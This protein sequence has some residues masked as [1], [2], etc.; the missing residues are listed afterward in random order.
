ML[1]YL[2]HPYLYTYSPMHRTT[3]KEEL[4]YD[5]MVDSH[6]RS[7][8]LSPK[9]L[10]VITLGQTLLVCVDFSSALR[11]APIQSRG[12]WKGDLHSH[13]GSAYAVNHS[14]SKYDSEADTWTGLVD[15]WSDLGE[16]FGSSLISG[17]IYIIGT[18]PDRQTQ[19]VIRKFSLLS[20]EDTSL[21]YFDNTSTLPLVVYA[22]GRAE[23]ALISDSHQILYQ[24]D[25]STFSQA[26]FQLDRS[27]AVLQHHSETSVFVLKETGYILQIASGQ[28]WETKVQD[29][30]EESAD[31]ESV[32][33]LLEHDKRVR[34][35]PGL[36]TYAVNF[37]E[38]DYFCVRLDT[39][40]LT[41]KVIPAKGEPLIAKGAGIGL[42]PSG[43][44]MLAGGFDAQLQPTA[45]VMVWNPGADLRSATT[46][47]PHA[48]AFVVLA[49]DAESVYALGNVAEIEQKQRCEPAFQSYFQRYD[50]E[51]GLWTILAAPSVPLM[52]PGI[53]VL[54]G[55]IYSFCGSGTSQILTFDPA[56][57]QWH[58]IAISYPETLSLVLTF[59]LG[60]SLLCFSGID[61]S[62]NS[63]SHSSYLF[64]GH[65]FSRRQDCPFTCDRAIPLFGYGRREGLVCLVDSSGVWSAY[66]WRRDCWTRELELA[67]TEEGREGNVV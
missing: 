20:P 28:T 18:A 62:T 65:C 36:Y 54:K 61:I 30:D 3:W 63:P 60:D 23:I 67:V 13:E 11:L 37:E 8:I 26:S 21:L 43:E 49:V 42:L 39:L 58:H 4:S 25:S 14:I 50:L 41:V 19:G 15:Y 38:E 45:E 32:S 53:A 56:S 46:A 47:L 57:N 22:V 9:E 29:R 40:A 51:S 34:N 44:L 66:D 12:I 6:Y 27:P 1:Y 2:S 35:R 59:N 48:Q 64:D 7:C 24:V 17:S 5:G 16:Y 52:C 31:L 10:L 33:T 55:T